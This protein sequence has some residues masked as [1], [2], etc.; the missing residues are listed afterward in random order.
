LDYRSAG[1]DIELGRA[2]V[3]GIRER[4]EGSQAQSSG[5]SGTLGGIGGFAG[6]LELPAGYRAPVL[7]AGT[8]GV[9]TKL[10][11]AQQWG[12]HRGVGIDLVAMCVN[13]VLTVGARPLFFLD[14]IATGKLEPE[15]LWQVIDGILEGCQEAG[16]QLLGGGDGRDAGVL[17]ARQVRPGGFLRRDRREG[18]RSR[19][20]AGAAWGSVVGLAQQRVAQQR[21]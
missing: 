8:D 12:Q 21:L 20:L 14:Y 4:V 11:I 13:D 3:K 9:G 1:V 17:P 10:E 16:C 7:V 18:R 15:A 2:F 5:S 19:Q 6:L